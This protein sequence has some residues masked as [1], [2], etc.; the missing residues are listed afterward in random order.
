M[1]LMLLAM[2]TFLPSPRMI[3]ETPSEISLRVILRLSISSAIVEYLTIGPATSYGNSEMYSK[4]FE[5]DLCTS[6]LPR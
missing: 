2:M 6:T 3:L 1:V 5:Y 4:S